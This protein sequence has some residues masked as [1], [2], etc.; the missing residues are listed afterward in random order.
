MKNVRNRKNTNKSETTAHT[1]LEFLQELV[2]ILLFSQQIQAKYR[3]CSIYWFY[4]G[5]HAELQIVALGDWQLQ[6][7]FSCVYQGD[8]DI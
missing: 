6:Q 5:L 4:A 8:A 1:I 3:A 2:N 7:I